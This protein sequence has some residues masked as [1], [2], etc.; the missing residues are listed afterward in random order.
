MLVGQFK[1][2]TPF[3][4]WQTVDILLY[5]TFKKGVTNN[6]KWMTSYFTDRNQIQD[7]VSKTH[8]DNQ[9][10]CQR[11]FA[12]SRAFTDAQQCGK[13]ENTADFELPFPHGGS[14]QR[15]ASPAELYLAT[16]PLPL[17]TV[18]QAFNQSERNRFAG[19]QCRYKTRQSWCWREFFGYHLAGW[20]PV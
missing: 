6:I 4:W 5:R 19:D 13:R 3:K 16:R 9:E 10:L 1:F 14:S 2:L 15:E 7:V 11:S 18:L 20:A 17:S 12:K 8:T